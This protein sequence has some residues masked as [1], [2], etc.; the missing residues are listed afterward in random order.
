VSVRMLCESKGCV[1]VLVFWVA[2]G[3]C[4]CLCVV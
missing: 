4:V 2:A 3:V 1:C